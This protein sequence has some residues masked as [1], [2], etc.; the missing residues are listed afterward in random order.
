MNPSADP[1]AMA[2][3]ADEFRTSPGADGWRTELVRG[4][5]V[6][7]PAP[8][9]AHGRLAARLAVRLGTFVENA[10]SGVV[11]AD[12]GFLLARDPDTVRAPDLSFVSTERIPEEG[13]GAGFWPLGPDLAVEIL[14]PSNTASDLQ[15][16]IGDYLAAG[17]HEIWVLDPAARSVAVYGADRR[18][19][20]FSADEELDGGTLLPGFVLP[21]GELFG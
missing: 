10:G 19:R 1:A 9:P 21:L 3:S 12:A 5:V 7:E 8:G 13:Y 14:S 2:V 18:A 20:V 17:C 15:A 11:L 16:K 4:R 6:R